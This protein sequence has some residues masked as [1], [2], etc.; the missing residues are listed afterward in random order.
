MSLASHRRLILFVALSAIPVSASSQSVERIVYAS[1]L[2]R[3]GR[4]VTDVTANGLT[5]RENNI[6]RRVLRVYRAIEP[7][8]VA[9]LVDTSQ[10]AEVLF[11]DFR[12]GSLILSERWAIAMRSR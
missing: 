8:D 12:R 1:I 7:L 2:D 6:D 3:A 9:I 10:D 5:V 4:P 11:A